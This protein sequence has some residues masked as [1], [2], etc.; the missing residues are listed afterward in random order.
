MTIANDKRRTEEQIAAAQVEEKR[1]LLEQ[2]KIQKAF[3]ECFATESGKTVLRWM[4]DQCNYQRP[5]IAANPQTGESLNT[6]LYAE[7]RRTLY[8]RIRKFLHRDILDQVEI[9]R[10]SEG[11]DG[12]EDL[13]T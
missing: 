3:C 4:M 5:L 11:A 6:T 2:K 7:G 10:G 9:E 1:K 8:L 13:L 12:S